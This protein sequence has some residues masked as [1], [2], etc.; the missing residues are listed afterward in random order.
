ML[1]RVH[2]IVIVLV[3]WFTFDKSVSVVPTEGTSCGYYGGLDS[4]E[5]SMLRIFLW[6]P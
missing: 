3:C 4:E 1:V 5:I 2:K 6:N